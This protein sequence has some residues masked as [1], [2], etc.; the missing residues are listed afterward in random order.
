MLALLQCGIYNKEIEMYQGIISFLLILL[1]SFQASAQNIAT[2]GNKKITLKDFKRKF[3]LAQDQLNPPTPNQFLEDLIRYEVGLIEARKKGVHKDKRVMDAMNNQIYG[4]YVEGELG[5]K[6]KA[7]KITEKEM[8]AQY[9]KT[10]ELRTSHIVINLK[11]NATKKQ[12]AIA[13]KRSK[14]IYKKVKSSKRPFKDLVKLYSDDTFTKPAGGDLGYQSL[15]TALPNYYN[16][17]LKMRVGKV[18]GL[19]ETK[20]GFHIIKLTGI[21]KFKHADPRQI[22]SIVFELKRKKLFDKLFSKLKRK[23]KITKKAKLLKNL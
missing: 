3:V 23:Y 9:K 2:V 18:H 11:A 5:K 20:Y 4:Y 22:K 15:I 12:K 7:I 1:F 14:E 19:I 17:A 6:V 8:R 10:P 13:K 21:R 16:A